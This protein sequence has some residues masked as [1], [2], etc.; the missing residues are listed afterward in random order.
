[1]LRIA[2]VDDAAAL[3]LLGERTFRDAFSTQNT[4]E[5]MDTYIERTYREEYQRRELLDPLITTFVV[6]NDGELIAFA[7]CK[8]GEDEIE[9]V[10]IYVDRRFHGG[11]IAQQLMNAVEEF[12]R[13][14]RVSRLWLGVW[15]HNPRAIKFYE[16]CGFRVT[17]SHP[18]VL[19]SDVQ[20][21]LIMEKSV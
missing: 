12:T 2:T 3:A 14:A 1:M 5:D 21:D 8:R 4:P 13:N 11:G 9:L 10:R 7:Q 17:G 15:E 19:G 18:F 16:K 20:T 6:E